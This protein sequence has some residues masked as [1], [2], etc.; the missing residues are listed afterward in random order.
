MVLLTRHLR[1]NGEKGVLSWC[2]GLKKRVRVMEGGMKLR[3]PAKVC[4]QREQSK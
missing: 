4:A 2:M 3:S 1:S